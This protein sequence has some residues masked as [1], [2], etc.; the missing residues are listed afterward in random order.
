ML[1]ELLLTGQVEEY[2]DQ[3]AL[4]DRPC[5]FV[6]IPKTAGTSLRTEIAALLQPD[7]N[8]VVDYED[9]SRSFHERMDGAVDVF[10]ANNAAEPVRFA[11]GHILARHVQRIRQQIPSA[12][13]VTFLRDPVARVISDY[14]YQRSPRHPVY[15]DFVASV[16]SLEAYLEL[17]SEQNKMAQHLIPPG[18]LLGGDP[19][20]CVDSMMRGYD[21]IGVQE[22]YPIS[23]RTLMSLVGHPSWPKLQEN[24]N[25]DNDEERNVSPDMANRIREVNAIDCALY[26]HVFPRL[27]S[28]RD[29]L[30]RALS[31]RS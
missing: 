1:M 7:V 26:D 15:A 23:F 21:F 9:T 4:G 17:R 12:S 16:P 10:L 11:S 19:Q 20:E 29:R 18:I 27:V 8:I 5:V 3:A 13:F 25:R 30:T 28:V 24:V 14:R 31:E 6:H 2:L 22:M